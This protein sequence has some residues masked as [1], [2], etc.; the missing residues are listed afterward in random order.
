LAEA[1]VTWI[2]PGIES[3]ST[4]VLHLMGKG[5]TSLQNIQLL[6]YC[7]KFGVLPSWSI[8]TGFPGEKAE[9][10]YEIERLI[11]RKITHLPPP[12][13]QCRFTLQRFSPYF[14]N[15]EES[16]ILNVRP[17]EAYAFIY[18]LPESS[19]HNLAY[20]FSFDY[21]QDVKPPDYEGELT[22]AV[23]YW[24]SCYERGETLVCQIRDAETL[25]ISDSRSSAKFNQITLTGAQKDIYEYCHQI[26]GFPSI[27]SYVRGQHN[28]YPIRERDVRDFLEEMVFLNLMVSENNKYLSLAIPIEDTHV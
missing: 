17:E 16:G 25:L 19:L 22:Q 13:S 11:Y 28:H 18:P 20:N 9:D 23:D 24:K 21:R 26:R 2:Q 6:K 12:Q 1:G 27:F 4:H 14:Q 15:P 3:L 7:K 10:S 5:V 8:L